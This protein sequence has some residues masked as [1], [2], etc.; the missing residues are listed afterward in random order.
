MHCSTECWSNYIIF[1][2]FYASAWNYSS[3]WVLQFA[4]VRS[5]LLF[6]DVQEGH[7]WCRCWLKGSYVFPW[8]RLALPM[9]IGRVHA[10][11]LITEAI[12]VFKI[13]LSEAAGVANLLIPTMVVRG[14]LHKRNAL[15]TFS[16]YMTLYLMCGMSIFLSMMF[17]NIFTFVT[18]PLPCWFVSHEHV[19]LITSIS[20]LSLLVYIRWTWYLFIG[21]APYI[22]LSLLRQHKLW[23]K[24]CLCLYLQGI[25]R[26]PKQSRLWM[27]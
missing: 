24:V 12:N 16:D 4:I 8:R 25:G 11:R 21:C 3:K 10:L 17:R 19:K 6:W 20:L 18:L 22:W 9:P 26:Y 2:S 14:P 27:A 13:F 1:M 5:A 23:A 15:C 7:C